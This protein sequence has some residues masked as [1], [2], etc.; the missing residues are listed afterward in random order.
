[1]LVI[2]AASSLFASAYQKGTEGQVQSAPSFRGNG[3]NDKGKRAANR[4]LAVTDD[5]ITQLSKLAAKQSISVRLFD[6][7]CTN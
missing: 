6:L 1:M 7:R 2:D 5:L 4:K 3:K